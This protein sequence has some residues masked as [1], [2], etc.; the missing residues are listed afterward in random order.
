MSPNL[1]VTVTNMTY[2]IGDPV[3]DLATILPERADCKNSYFEMTPN[4]TTLGLAFVVKNETDRSEPFKLSVKTGL[5]DLPAIGN[6]T[7]NITEVDFYEANSA[8]YTV[9]LEVLDLVPTF[10]SS[11]HNQTV[12]VDESQLVAN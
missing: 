4:S 8:L 3:L 5:S 2:T 6:L 12:L 1:P 7:V 9:N 11:R 10:N